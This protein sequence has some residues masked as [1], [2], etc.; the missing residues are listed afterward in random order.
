MSTVGVDGAAEA[1]LGHANG[2]TA[3]I[4]TG[5]T[6]PG[7]GGGLSSTKSAAYLLK[8]KKQISSSFSL[9]AESKPSP[10]T[11]AAAG[12]GLA[13]ELDPGCPRGAGSGDLVTVTSSYFVKET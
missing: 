2:H 13:A 4:P 1:L 9:P 6:K 5:V 8:K 11:S 10:D 7:Q 3:G 12:Q